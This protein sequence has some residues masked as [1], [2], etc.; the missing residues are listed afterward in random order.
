MF[1]LQNRY[2]LCIRDRDMQEASLANNILAHYGNAI[3]KKSG[4]LKNFDERYL[5]G[6]IDKQVDLLNTAPEIQGQ[7]VMDLI[8]A[9]KQNNARVS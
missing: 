1:W 2:M 8:N 6:L 5:Q 3:S 7:T 4:Q 9:H